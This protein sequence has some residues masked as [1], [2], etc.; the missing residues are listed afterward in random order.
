MQKQRAKKRGGK[1]NYSSYLA[2]NKWCK[3]VAFPSFHDVDDNKG[4]YKLLATMLMKTIGKRGSATE[5]TGS[6]EELESNGRGGWCGPNFAS[7]AG[8]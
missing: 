5:V 4:S 1:G 7:S 6:T 2:A 8:L 3:N